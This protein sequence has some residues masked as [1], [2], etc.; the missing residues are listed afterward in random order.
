MSRPVRVWSDI[1][2]RIET[3]LRRGDFEGGAGLSPG[4]NH[5]SAQLT[6][7]YNEVDGALIR[8]WL[9][10]NNFLTCVKEKRV[11]IEAPQTVTEETAA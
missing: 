11:R 2:I 3:G 10:Q 8:S 9:K 6:P 7:G 5:Q 1:A 4:E